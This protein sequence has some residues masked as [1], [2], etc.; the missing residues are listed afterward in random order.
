M[1]EIPVSIVDHLEF[2]L[3]NYFKPGLGEQTADVIAGRAV[4]TQIGCASC[5][6]ASMVV[7]QDRRVADL[8]TVFD[9]ER[10]NPFNRLFA[11]A[12]PLVVNF[13][14]RYRRQ[15]RTSRPQAASPA[16]IRGP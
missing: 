10:G 16:A 4:F 5:H 12:T 8:E 7:Q 3:L 15:Q 1:N 13:P 11:T 2:Y 9:E 14:G 6:L